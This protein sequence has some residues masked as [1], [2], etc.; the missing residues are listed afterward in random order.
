PVPSLVK[1]VISFVVFLALVAFLVLA[2]RAAVAGRKARGGPPV[3]ADAAARAQAQP[4]RHSGSVLAAVGALILATTLGVARD[5]AAA[6][7]PTSTPDS[8]VE[9]IGNT[10]TVEVTM[11]D[12]RFTPDV[13]EVPA[14]DRLVIELSNID[15]TIHDL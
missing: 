3:P 4:K 11:K 6:G 1:V 9:A 13:I 8:S 10:T 12:M 14:G 15:D 5:P 2:V 7:L